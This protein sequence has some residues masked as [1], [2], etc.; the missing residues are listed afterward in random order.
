MGARSV[1]PSLLSCVLV[2]LNLVRLAPPLAPPHPPTHPACPRAQLTIWGGHPIPPA[3]CTPCYGV[4]QQVKVRRA[5]ALAP[6]PRRCYRTRSHLMQGATFDLAVAFGTPETAGVAQAPFIAAA[7]IS[8]ANR[9]LTLASQSLGPTAR[10]SNASVTA[11]SLPSF[12][13]VE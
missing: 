1:T 3:A 12:A 13:E 5:R 9:A 10:A 2:P 7:L 6:Q 11:W 8:A 4:D